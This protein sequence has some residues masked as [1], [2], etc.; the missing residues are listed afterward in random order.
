MG[1]ESGR[2]L[3]KI[4]SRICSFLLGFL[5][6]WLGNL[7]LGVKGENDGLIRKTIGHGWC[8]LLYGR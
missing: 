5:G 7:F 3:F 8:Q 4:C 1:E 2:L 6:L